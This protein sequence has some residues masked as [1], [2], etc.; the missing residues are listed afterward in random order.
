VSLPRFRIRTLMIAVAVAAL[1]SEMTAWYAG[2]G[3][4][5][6]EDSVSLLILIGFLILVFGTVAVVLI[7]SPSPERP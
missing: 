7:C 1:V 5:E 2:V 3:E 4:E 6:R